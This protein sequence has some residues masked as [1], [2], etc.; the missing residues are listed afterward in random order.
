[1]SIRGLSRREIESRFDAVTEF[2]GI[3]D[4]I[5]APVQTYSSGMG[6]RLGFA[7]AVHTEPDIIIVDEMLAVG[8]PRF[9]AKC[10]RKVGELRERGTAF[11]LVS[12]NE[13]TILSVCD[14]VVYLAKGQVA[15]TGPPE[16]VIRR[17]EEDLGLYEGGDG[18]GEFVVPEHPSGSG[19]SLRAMALQDGAGS[20][21]KWLT[22]GEPASLAVRIRADRPRGDVRVTL[23]VTEQ[24]EGMPVVLALNSLDDVGPLALPAGESVLRLTLPF[25]VLR[26]G[27]YAA[28]VTV[29]DGGFLGILDQVDG[30]RFAVRPGRAGGSQLFQPRGWILGAASD[31]V[32][33]A[34]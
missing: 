3:G 22:T 28:R 23:R 31:G 21:L 12:H 8:D 4:A 19:V 7:C 27:A 18:T 6:A 1:M 15:A 20:P 9:R 24:T 16:A 32:P 2:A 26:P 33:G 30:F 11:I 5:D 17:Y 34:G 10:Y 25:C 29:S 13:L 14:S